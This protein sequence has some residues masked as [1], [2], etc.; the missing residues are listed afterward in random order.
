MQQSDK[1]KRLIKKGAIALLLVFLLCYVFYIFSE[2]KIKNANLVSPSASLNADEKLI[3]FALNTLA[4]ND[5]FSRYL[6]SLEEQ[7]FKLKEIEIPAQDYHTVL[8]RMMLENSPPDIFEISPL[9]LDT[10]IR[11]NWLAKPNDYVDD[12]SLQL[13]KQYA[14]PVDKDNSAIPTLYQSVFML[15]NDELLKANG[16]DN[17]PKSFDELQQ[18]CFN[19]SQANSG[20]GKFGF[21]IP[22]EFN[23]V[24]SFY[25]LEHINLAAGISNYDPTQHLYRLELIKPVLD[26]MQKMRENGAL[27]PNYALSNIESTLTQFA[28][29]NIGIVFAD[30]QQIEKLKEIGTDFKFT[31]S[32][33]PTI[34][35]DKTQ[36]VIQTPTGFIGVS[37]R[38]TNKSAAMSKLFCRDMLDAVCSENGFLCIACDHTEYYKELISQPLDIDLEIKNEWIE[39]NAYSYERFALYKRIFDKELSIISLQELSLKL[40]QNENIRRKVLN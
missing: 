34:N 22:L 33:P 39:S 20:Y 32:L 10:Y 1:K 17:P 26:A 18:I 23:M 4:E 29:G 3:T 37:S 5:S 12:D 31:I 40:S 21:L 24:D 15:S 7:G 11:K 30:L 27:S 6:Y 16:Y 14:A 8:N 25:A 19:I 13:L 2:P 38:S 35:D 36:S 28:D 9:W